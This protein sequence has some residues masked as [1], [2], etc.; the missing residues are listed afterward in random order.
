SEAHASRGFVTGVYD[1]DWTKAEREFK[2]AIKAKPDY[3]TAYEWYALCLSWTGRHDEAVA[4][5][6]RAQR[7]DP[8]TPIITSVVGVVLHFAGHYEEA[9]AEYD[10]VLDMDPNFI[11]ALCFRGAAYTQLGKF[12]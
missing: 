7:L 10:K 9:L 5:A 11:P 4:M 2:K 6:R 3:A 12:K 8:L 1:W